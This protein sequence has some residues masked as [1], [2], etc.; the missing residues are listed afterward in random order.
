VD[1][2]LHGHTH[3]HPDRGAGR[4]FFPHLISQPFRTGLHEAFA[5]AIGACLVAA[6]ASMMRG[7]R[8]HAA[9]ESEQRAAMPKAVP[10]RPA[11]AE[12]RRAS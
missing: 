9:D 5:F 11:R 1:V 10:L 4:S 3:A 7:G 2:A 8:Y 12:E 6:A